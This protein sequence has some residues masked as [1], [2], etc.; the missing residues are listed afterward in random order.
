MILFRSNKLKKGTLLLFLFFNSIN[1][2]AQ[3][4]NDDPCSATP[5]TVGTS[6]SYSSY[7]NAAATASAGVPAPGCAS[8]SGGDVWFSI[9]VPASG[10]VT[11]NSLE[12]VMTDAGMAVYSGT[13]GSLTLIE[14]DDDDS[15]NGYMS[16]IALSGQTPGNTL[17]I[18]FWEY[19]NNNNGTFSICSY[20][21]APPPP[22]ND[23]PCSATTLTVGA[24]CSYSTYTNLNAT[25]SSGV[26]AP[27][28]ASYSGGDVWFS[29]TVPANGNLIVDGTSGVIT[30]GGM[31]IYSG[32]CGALTL[33]ECDDDDSPNGAMPY[34]LLTGQ[35]PGSTLWIRIWEY[36]NDNNGTFGICASEY[37]P[38]TPPSNDNCTGAAN[39]PVSTGVCGTLS[40]TVEFATASAQANSCSGTADDDVWYSFV[41]SS[42]SADISLNNVSGSAID[43]YHN[44]YSGTCGSVGAPI[45]CSDPNSSSLTGLTIGNTYYVRVF[46]YTSTPGQNTDFEICVMEM[47][48]CGTPNNQDYCVAPATLTEGPGNFSANTSDTYSSDEPADLYFEFC[49]SI[50]NN[51]W[52]TFTASSTSHSF[53]VIDVSG[54][55]CEDGIQAE[56]YQVTEDVNGCCTDFTSVSNCWNPG[57]ATTGTVSATGLTIGNQY[58]L[59]I[60]GYAGDHCNFTISG[61][62][63]VGIIA[64]NVDLI[65]FN[66]KAEK[67][68]TSLKWVTDNENNNDH[69]NVL[70]SDDGYNFRE[71]GQ[72]KGIGTTTKKSN[73]TFNDYSI[74]SGISYYKLEQVDFDGTAVESEIISVERDPSIKLNLYP[75]PTEDNITVEFVL[76]GQ[77]SESDNSIQLL[78]IDGTHIQDYTFNSTSSKINISLEGLKKGIYLVRFTNS[79][80]GTVT[81]QIIKK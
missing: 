52:Y 24:T 48:A 3:P 33:I 19:G 59:M 50:E 39:V 46:T 74:E 45:V 60:D 22:S 31:A 76:S 21:P 61:W 80:E 81:K 57:I 6:C 56:V 25:A 72:V 35:T 78:N 43:L 17:W 28:C 13:C 62:S 53:P 20:N 65:D 68:Y 47:T 63:A 54:P 64:L 12:G 42:T 51:S 5:L 11:I 9:T 79:I 44:V 27:G 55:S 8:Y 14:C 38:P 26:P 18:R 4:S 40:G 29:V 69:F 73:Y 58:I 70:K 10:Q 67:N 75:N 23:D 1:V 36:G 2:F 7:T 49:G 66:G 34:I 77:N 16:M 41:A 30:D 37:T 71:I 32:T 15:P